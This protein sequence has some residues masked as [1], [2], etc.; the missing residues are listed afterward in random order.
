M[1]VFKTKTRVENQVLARIWRAAILRPKI[2]HIDKILFS[3]L[4]RFLA[5]RDRR[6]REKAIPSSSYLPLAR[7]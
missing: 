6:I 1:Q 3:V 7:W 4:F 2:D 5:S